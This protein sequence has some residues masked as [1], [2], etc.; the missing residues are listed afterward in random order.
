MARYAA[1]RADSLS[2]SRTLR[3]RR[4]VRSEEHT[5]ELQSQSNLVCR[6]LL[7]KKKKLNQS[8]YSLLLSRANK[9]VA[10]QPHSGEKHCL[11]STTKQD[12]AHP[13]SLDRVSQSWTCTDGHAH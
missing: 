1:S 11:D 10:R 8:G 13:S 2:L 5:S 9:N 12:S 6:L 7:E 3:E 4:A